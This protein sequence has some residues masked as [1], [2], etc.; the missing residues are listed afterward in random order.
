VAMIE[1]L[2][3]YYKDALVIGY[4][5]QNPHIMEWFQTEDGMVFG[6]KK[7]QLHETEKKLLEHLFS[8]ISERHIHLSGEERIWYNYLFKK[9]KDM[10]SLITDP[11]PFYRFIQFEL[12]KMIEHDNFLEALQGHFPSKILVLWE[13]EKSGII[14]EGIRSGYIETED[15]TSMIDAFAG[16]FYV[17]IRM[18][19]GQIHPFQQQIPSDFDFE[20][21]CFQ[22]AR[23]FMKKQKVSFLEDI[24]LFLFIE[25]AEPDMVKKV[26]KFILKDV[27]ND[28]ELLE[29]IKVFIECNLNVTKAAKKMYM[30]RNSVQYRIDKFI[31]KTGIDIKHLKGALAV[32][33]AILCHQS[34]LHS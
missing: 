10:F 27:Q 29:T 21:Q 1:K 15:F 28:K 19:V 12:D 31:E 22:K 30:H 24:V 3:Q 18:Y 33:V 2:K 34:F 5:V 25:M 13:N 11:Y 9:N 23:K 26:T 16:D 4:H 14:I 20:K 32:Y 7:D 17:N 8:K 6:I